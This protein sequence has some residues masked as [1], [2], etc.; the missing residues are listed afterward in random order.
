MKLIV[1]SIAGQEP[2]DG[3]KLGKQQQKG[4]YKSPNGL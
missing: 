3:F 2:V 4:E 1:S